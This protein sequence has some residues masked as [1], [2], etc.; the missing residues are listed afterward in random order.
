MS[1]NLNDMKNKPCGYLGKSVL[2]RGN[3][4]YKGPGVGACMHAFSR[5]IKGASDALDC[6]KPGES[7]KK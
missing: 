5:N 1:R 2:S 4:K 6:V 7:G 3:S